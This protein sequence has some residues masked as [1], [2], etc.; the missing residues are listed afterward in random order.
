VHDQS[1]GEGY[2]GNIKRT[3]VSNYEEATSDVTETK[4]RRNGK[5]YQAS[6]QMASEISPQ[7]LIPKREG[8]LF[9]ESGRN[10]TN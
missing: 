5:G 10:Q 8:S 6:A 4:L 2:E 1:Q 7:T 9:L 3:G